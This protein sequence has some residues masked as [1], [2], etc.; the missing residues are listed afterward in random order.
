MMIISHM[1]CVCVCVFFEVKF[2]R[3]L[4]KKFEK[5]LE[6]FCFTSGNSTSF[7]FS[8]FFIKKILENFNIQ[9]RKKQTNTAHVRRKNSLMNPIKES[10][11]VNHLYIKEPKTLA[12]LII[13]RLA[14]SSY[15]QQNQTHQSN[16]QTNKQTKNQSS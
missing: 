1:F 5:I 14:S 13:I 4:I 15:G 3:F 8:F 7:S 11:F 9:K 2:C 10:I 6:I 16:K 12:I